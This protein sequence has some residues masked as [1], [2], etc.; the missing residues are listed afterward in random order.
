[1]TAEP[2][3]ERIQEKQHRIERLHQRLDDRRERDFEEQFETLV[4][5]RRLFLDEV[6]ERIQ[7]GNK[8]KITQH[9]AEQ[10][11][12]KEATGGLAERQIGGFEYG[13]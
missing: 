7:G 5:V 4:E 2:S 8:R 12:G 13:D 6:I 9:A 11:R 1:V 3:A 10:S